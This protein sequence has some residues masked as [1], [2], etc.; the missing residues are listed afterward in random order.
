MSRLLPTND[1]SLPFPLKEHIDQV[2][3]A[4]EDAWRAGAN[5][6]VEDYLRDATEGEHD[7]LL[8]ELLLDVDYRGRAG[9]MVEVA[10]YRARFPRNKSLIDAV[11]RFSLDAVAAAAQFR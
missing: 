3:L 4:F 10:D 8:R 2:C 11:F 1:A 5:P 6:R 7:A 9:E